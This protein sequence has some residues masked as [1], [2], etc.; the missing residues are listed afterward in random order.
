MLYLK[1]TQK[2][3]T[4]LENLLFPCRIFLNKNLNKIEYEINSKLN[5]KVINKS[6]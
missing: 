6:I 1:H 5:D 4:S 3:I 2:N